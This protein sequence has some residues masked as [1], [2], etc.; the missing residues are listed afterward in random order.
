[1]KLYTQDKFIEKERTEQIVLG[2][3][4]GILI[5]MMLYNLFIYSSAQDKN[6]L[7]LV[8]FILSFFVYI[9][10]ENGIAYE[11]LWP[12]LP[13]WSKRAVPFF[14]SMVI[15]TSSLFVQS[16]IETKR[17]TPRLDRTISLFRI[18]AEV[19]DTAPNAILVHDFEGR[20][21]YANQK[22][23][24]MHGYD[25]DEF[26]A[27]NLHDI[28]VPESKKQIE[29][30]MKQVDNKGDIRFEVSHFRK[31]GSTFPMLINVK[32]TNWGGVNLPF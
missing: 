18:L 32:K 28:D 15:I 8:M 27:I 4:Y 25:K 26:M 29:K 19:V 22:T 10:S 11:Y 16:F 17:N 6:Y 31:D 21:I 20:M 30:R 1:M 24:E 2:L 14:V 12:G 9:L 5:I 7:Y 3:F 23:F 13:W